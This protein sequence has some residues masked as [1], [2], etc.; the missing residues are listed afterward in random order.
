MKLL[1]VILAI[2]IASSQAANAISC[3]NK[4][5]FIDQKSKKTLVF[6]RGHY[7]GSGKLPSS[8][9]MKVAKLAIKQFQLEKLAT[10]KKINILVTGSSHLGF[11]PEE[12]Q[13]NH[14]ILASHSGGYVGMW[15]T[16]EAFSEEQERIKSIIML[17]SWYSTKKAF[18]QLIDSFKVPCM[19]FLTQ[20]N[21]AR[22]NKYYKPLGCM[23]SGPSGYTHSG[24]VH[25]YLL[26][27]L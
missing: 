15:E 13:G 24:S 17:D 22:Y 20:H 6:L 21:L 10:T 14:I 19:G 1:S 2:F 25:N 16:L 5:C 11:S 3:H 9:F 27:H 23:A 12:I 4:S 7:K 8:Q 26:D 18:H